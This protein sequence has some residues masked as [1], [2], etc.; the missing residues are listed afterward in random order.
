MIMNWDAIGA[1]G[2]VLGAL[3][4][5]ATLLYLAR[6]ISQTNQIS[7]TSVARDLQQKYSDLYTLIASDSGVKALVA[8]LRKSDYTPE[9]EEEEEQLE[10]F[11]LLLAGL[12][13]ST[14]VAHA[15]GQIEENMY[16]VYCKDVDVKLSKWP[17]MRSQM[18]DLLKE[19][20]S[21]ATFEIFAPILV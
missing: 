5:I 11:C 7:K 17:G 4:V 12:W 9:S 14:G 13:L 18:R 8:R 19:Y 3:V 10:S 6:Q 20:P 21:A 15:Q 1:V 16:Q 2:E